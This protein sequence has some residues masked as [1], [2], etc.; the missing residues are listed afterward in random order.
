M[1][2]NFLRTI[3]ASF[4][5]LIIF[6]PT[7][8]FSS[9]EFIKMRC[10]GERELILIAENTFDVQVRG[11]NDFIFTEIGRNRLNFSSKGNEW[12]VD[13][14]TGSLSMNGMSVPGLV[15]CEVENISTIEVIAPSTSLQCKI[16]DEVYLFLIDNDYGDVA[17]GG[18]IYKVVQFSNYIYMDGDAGVYTIERSTGNMY[19]GS[20]MIEGMNCSI[21]DTDVVVN[22]APLYSAN[23]NIDPT[24]ISSWQLPLPLIVTYGELEERREQFSY[25]FRLEADIATNADYDITVVFNI[26]FFASDDTFLG[27]C[28][29][30]EDI[31]TRDPA[32][33]RCDVVLAERP[34]NG[35]QIKYSVFGYKEN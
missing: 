5:I 3:I 21:E 20:S 25:E 34:A 19:E 8:A 27:G 7:Y 31:A 35:Y 2:L 24:N 12:S 32:S 16:G 33:L 4:L 14:T 22:T 9:S 29:E 15:T 10:S 13:L 6:A 30:E 26:G 28:S 23:G 1:S 11:G 18:D 17:I